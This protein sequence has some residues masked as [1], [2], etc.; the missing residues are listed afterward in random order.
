MFADDVRTAVLTVAT[1]M[2]GTTESIVGDG[3]ESF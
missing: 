2:F 3:I 1:D